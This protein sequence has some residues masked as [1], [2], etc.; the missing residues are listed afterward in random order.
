MNQQDPFIEQM[1]LALDRMLRDTGMCPELTP[2]V[3]RYRV[4]HGAHW[5]FGYTTRPVLKDGKKRFVALLYKEYWEPRIG[6]MNWHVCKRVYFRR[7]WQAKDRAW[8]WY[9]AKR[10]IP[11][12]SLHTPRQ[13]DANDRERLIRQLAT[14]EE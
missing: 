2:R 8:K 5:Q 11:F 12:K 4:P 7:R 3:W 14:T 13:I 6:A 10:G 1:Q 9:C